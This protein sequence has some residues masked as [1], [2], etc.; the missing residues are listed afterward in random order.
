MM[1]LLISIAVAGSICNDGWVSASEGSGT[2]SHHAGVARF[3]DGVDQISPG[4][5]VPREK[6]PRSSNRDYDWTSILVDGIISQREEKWKLALEQS[7]M[8]VSAGLITPDRYISRA[9][10]VMI[11]R[12]GTQKE[13]SELFEEKKRIAQHEELSRNV[14]ARI[15]KE[16]LRTWAMYFMEPGNCST[17]TAD[18]IIFRTR[19]NVIVTLKKGEAA[20]VSLDNDSVAAYNELVSKYRSDGGI[21]EFC[22]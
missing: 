7:K 4:V 21:G 8:E 15:G 10:E 12:W 14:T 13:K 11:E 19:S 9:Q 3:C 22:P 1:L 18:S 20:R 6:C 17:V 5:F 2:C 16:H